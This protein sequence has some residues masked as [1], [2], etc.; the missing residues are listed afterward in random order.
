MKFSEIT[1]HKEIISALRESVDSGKIPHAILFSGISGIGKIKTA[2]AFAQ[3]IHCQNRQDGDSCGKCPSCLQHQNLNNPDLHFVYPIVKKEGAL[4]SKDL[5]EEWKELLSNYPYMPNE[6]WN[7]LIK[8]GN[9]QPA[10]FVNE[11]EEIISRASISAFQE[12][13]K[14]FIIWQPEKM[15]PEA[16]NKLLKIIEEPF[17]D[18]LFILVSNN[19]TKILPTILS[20]TQRFYFHPLETSEIE[21]ELIEKGVER[22][23]AKEAA[24]IAGGS[25][26]KAQEISLHPEELNDFSFL[27]KE[28]MRAA[29]S[30]NAKKLKELSEDIS[31]FG[32]E[33]VMRFLNYCQRM[34]RE[35]FISNFKINNLTAMTKDEAE[36]S[37]RFAPF[38]HEGNVEIISTELGRASSDIERN[39]NTKIVLFDLFLL[40]SRYVRSKKQP[41]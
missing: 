21:I 29:Y 13:L 32:R 31:G 35:N 25:L 38:I 11:S 40:L 6:R 24:R 33:K 37:S 27:F 5:I 3:Y 23:Q 4:I 16:A 18:T 22:E 39:V 15:R 26:E 14:I 41:K 20:R 28:I 9:S 7:E 17:E 10:I 1:G 19:D 30:L 12:N 34:I 36:F 8:A 2:R